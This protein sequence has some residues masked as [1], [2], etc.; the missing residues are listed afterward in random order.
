M[1][2]MTVTF[3]FMMSSMLWVSACQKT[4]PTNELEPIPK[5]NTQP[6]DSAADDTVVVDSTFSNPLMPGGPDPWVIQKDGTYYYTYTQGSKLVILETKSMSELASARRYEV[7]TPPADHP[8]S[9]NLWAPE[10]HEIDGK[11]Y[12]YFAADNGSNANHRMYVLENSSPTPVQGNWEMKGKISDSTSEWAIDGTILRHDGKMYMIWSGGNAG[13]PPQNI[14][15][16]PMSNPWTISGPKVMIATPTYAWEKNGNPINEGP[17]VLINPQGKVYIVYSGSG[18]WSDGYCL[19]LL[20]LKDDGDPLQA[21]D[22]TKRNHPVF[23]MRPESSIYG[24]GHNG[25]FK[26]PDGKEN[27][28]IYHARNVAN[29]GNA[30]RRPYIQRFSWHTDGSPNFGLPANP[31]LKQKRPAGEKWRK[32][33]SKKGWTVAG[34]SSEEPN[35]N[36]VAAAVIDDNINSI[37]I[38]RY[39]VN[40]T[41]YPDHYLTIDIGAAQPVDGFV[42]HQ[43]DGDRKIKELEIHVGND[44]QN[45][46]NLGTFTLSDVNLLRQFIDLAQTKQFRYFKLVPKSGYDNQQQPGLAEVGIFRN[47]D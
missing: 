16:A 2:R 21:A 43:K 11:W 17:Q 34:F 14:Y 25:F 23:S 5:S 32:I 28:M 24:P 47:S 30:T 18:Y 8:Y 4:N 46:E 31:A 44:N 9:K 22:W 41:K 27:W 45:W 37:W 7:Y 3:Y 10:L 19:G 29:D 12:F 40:P 6:V 38:T 13:A 33:Y 15:I 35:N 36:R 1:K 39:S 20:A 42:I 26:S